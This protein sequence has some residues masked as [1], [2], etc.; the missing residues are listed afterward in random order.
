MTAPRVSLLTT[1]FD[2]DP[3]PEHFAAC[4]ASI[5]AQTFT[6]WEHIVVRD[7]E[8]PDDLTAELD[9]RTRPE[10]QTTVRPDHGGRTAASADALAVS[11]G[12]LVV[13]VDADDV[14]VPQAL[15]RLVGAFDGSTDIDVVYSD[16]DVV[17]DDD[18]FAM[19]V[20]KPDFSP[21]R[22]RN[23]DYITRLVG[24]RREAVVA[25]G[26]FDGVHGH[27][28]LLRLAE[29]GRPFVHV[30]EVL[31]HQRARQDPIEI[32]EAAET[33]R[34]ENGRRAVAAHLE[35]IG[36]AATVE[37]GSTSGVYRIRREVIGRP[38]VSV[39][40]P[41]RGS[42][43]RIWGVERVLVHDAVA[44][45]LDDHSACDIEIVAVI[46]RDTDPLVE[47]GLRRIA[48]D[49]LRVV[50]FEP[51]FNFSAKINVG[52][53]AASGDFLLILNDD[54]QLQAPGSI[55]EMVALAQDT[56]VG[57]VGA[58]LVFDDGRLQHGGH[59]YNGVVAHA[60]LGWRAEHA[61]PHQL[62]AVE[63]ECAGV[64]AAAAL[65]PRSV[66][67]DVGGMDLDYDV[68]FNDV[69]YS[70]RIRATGR[71]IVWTPHACWYH[72][73]HGSEPRSVTPAELAK[74]E[75]QWGPSLTSD[76]FY[77]P[78]LMPDRCDWLERPRASAARL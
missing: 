7:A 22:L 27:D 5:D 36:M 20:F 50:D 2:P 56:T 51:P 62:L 33:R 57:M 34:A 74:L 60:L 10:R 47:R 32:D 53:D 26:G 71:R 11:H 29:G 70:L 49:A 14:L 55:D 61:G 9:R 76:P 6:D 65:V 37:T 64:T 30:P 45:I 12:D 15:E 54:T 8:T 46:D 66:H 16:H 41:T 58:K 43:Q 52:A 23:H 13:F 25:A 69:D 77:N 31:V 28:L 67:L 3:D 44:S 39:I 48:G 24:A 18:H 78:N 19:S 4:L 40:V 17:H 72:F 35:R 1:V 42:R 75:Q 68:N 59:V 73:E 21:E 63:R 38:T